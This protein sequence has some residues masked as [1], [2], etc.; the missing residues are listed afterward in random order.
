MACPVADKSVLA[1]GLSHVKGHKSNM[2][3]THLV[4]PSQPQDNSWVGNMH[5]MPIVDGQADEFNPLSQS[6]RNLG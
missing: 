6:S 1:C 4:R 2:R 3:Q 5:E